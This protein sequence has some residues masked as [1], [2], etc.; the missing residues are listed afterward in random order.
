MRDSL[1][2][3]ERGFGYT[4]CPVLLFTVAVRLLN[5]SP[6]TQ[7]LSGGMRKFRRAIGDDFMEPVV[8]VF[9]SRKPKQS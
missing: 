5:D 2:L 1:I 8:G 4:Q 3:F 7:N 6:V 9:A